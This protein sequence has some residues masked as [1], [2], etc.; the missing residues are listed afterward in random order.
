MTKKTQS[1]IKQIKNGRCAIHPSVPFSDNTR[2]K[3][4]VYLKLKTE[5]Q[6][7]NSTQYTSH[8]RYPSQIY[9]NYKIG[10]GSSGACL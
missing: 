1:K 3:R 8:I 2:N 10:P 9:L 6:L 4:P 5:I 7:K